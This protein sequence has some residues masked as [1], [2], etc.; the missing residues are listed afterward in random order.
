MGQMSAMS[1]A[2]CVTGYSNGSINIQWQRGRPSPA[3]TIT[4]DSNSI[5]QLN[6]HYHS[7]IQIKA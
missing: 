3:L 1:G 7:T 4:A 6:H 2:A 5:H